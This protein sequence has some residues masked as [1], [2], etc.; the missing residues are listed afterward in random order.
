MPLVVMDGGHLGRD[1]AVAKRP[2]SFDPH[3]ND[4]PGGEV[5][6]GNATVSYSL[7]GSRGDHVAG[8]QG[9]ALRAVT[10]ELADREDHVPA[11]RA[12][13]DFAV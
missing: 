13:Y 3:L 7:R 6:R 10:N 11:R 4:V 12:L 1:A 5:A 2:D 8:L 9:R